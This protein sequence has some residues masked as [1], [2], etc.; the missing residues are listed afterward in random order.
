MKRKFVVSSL[1]EN[2]HVEYSYHKVK[3]PG[4]HEVTI[5]VA[6]G[7]ELLEIVDPNKNFIDL[8]YRIHTGVALQSVNEKH[9]KKRGRAV[10][11]GY[12]TKKYYRGNRNG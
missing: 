6:T 9:N 10:S 3:L 7:T 5:T 4:G 1:P 8:Q 12:M 2:V 11:G